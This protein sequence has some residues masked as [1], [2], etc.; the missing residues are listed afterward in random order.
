MDKACIQIDTIY[1]SAYIAVRKRYYWFFNLL[2]FILFMSLSSIVMRML[3]SP[4]YLK[5]YNYSTIYLSF[6]AS[7]IMT[8]ICDAFFFYKSLKSQ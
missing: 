1:G 6:F 7:S 5:I 2:P 8:L 3:Y 4:R